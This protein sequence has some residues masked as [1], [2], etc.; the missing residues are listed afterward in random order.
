MQ[1]LSWIRVDSLG[2]AEPVVAMMAATNVEVIM[3][4]VVLETMVEMI[5][6]DFVPYAKNIDNYHV[7]FECL[8]LRQGPCSLLLGFLPSIAPDF[9]HVAA[10]ERGRT[11]PAHHT[12]ASADPWTA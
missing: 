2:E 7:A 12:D 10:G 8:S 5:L 9:P 3:D 1:L 11:N 6:F 4:A